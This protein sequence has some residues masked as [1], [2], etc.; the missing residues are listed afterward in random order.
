MQTALAQ[1]SFSESCVSLSQLLLRGAWL[2]AMAGI[3]PASL[4]L[5]GQGWE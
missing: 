1:G 2:E 4:S 5:S 3:P